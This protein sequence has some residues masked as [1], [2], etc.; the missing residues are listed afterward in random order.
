MKKIEFAKF[1]KNGMKAV[2]L[3]TMIGVGAQQ[4]VDAMPWDKFENFIRK[5]VNAWNAANS[6]GY[7][8]L[9]HDNGEQSMNV[10]ADGERFDYYSDDMNK[11]PKKTGNPNTIY[12][13]EMDETTVKKDEKTGE[14]VAEVIRHEFEVKNEVVGKF[15]GSKSMGFHPIDR[16]STGIAGSE[17]RQ[18]A[19]SGNTKDYWEHE[20]NVANVPEWKENFAFGLFKDEKDEAIK[21]GRNLGL[22]E[23]LTK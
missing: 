20:S 4:G 5:G 15:L 1:A 12:I 19:V 14:A 10:D 9:L 3:A 21:E 6:Q 8:V 23:Y 13:Y 17:Y 7:D 22:D 11:M 16:I 2:A 18:F